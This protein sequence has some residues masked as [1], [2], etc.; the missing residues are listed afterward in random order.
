MEILSTWMEYK[1]NRPCITIFLIGSPDCHTVT[2]VI[3]GSV[4]DFDQ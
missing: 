4:V 3:H 1:G 2:I